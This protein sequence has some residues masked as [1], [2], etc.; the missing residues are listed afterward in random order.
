VRE[1]KKLEDGK[2]P[3]TIQEIDTDLFGLF[4]LFE[5]MG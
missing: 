5:Y 1:R 2:S 3:I 4:L